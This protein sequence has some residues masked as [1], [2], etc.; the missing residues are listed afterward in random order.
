MEWRESRSHVVRIGTRVDQRYCEVEM[1]VLH[2]EQ[3]RAHA[4]A[5]RA[6]RLPQHRLHIDARGEKRAHHVEVAL[7]H[8]KEDGVAPESTVA[9]MSAPASISAPTTA[10]C[11]SAAA[12]IKAVWPRRSRASVLAPRTRSAF[13]AS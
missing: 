2:R 9:F 4:P 7:T 6:R 8:G 11:P 10:A 13:T 12:H 5:R 3:Q 1:A